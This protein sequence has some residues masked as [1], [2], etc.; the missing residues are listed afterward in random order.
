[1]NAWA[2]RHIS[3]RFGDVALSAITPADVE[4]WLAELRMKGLAAS[5][6]N[7]IL[8][9]LKS[10]FALAI[11]TCHIAH[12]RSP[13]REIRN[14]RM[15]PKQPRSLSLKEGK[16]LLDCLR[17]IHRPE[18]LI[19]QLLLLTGARK[20]EILK[21]RWEFLDCERR[22]LTVPCSKS[23]KQR[24]IYL[25]EEATRLFR[26]IK[27]RDG[28]PWILPDRNPQKPLSDVYRFWNKIRT[29]LGLRDTRIHDLRHSFASYLVMDGHT[30]Y[31]A[32]QLLG[33]SDPR[34]TMRYAHF[35]QTTL[36]AATATL[37]S[38]FRMGRHSHRDGG[39]EEIREDSINHFIYSTN[40]LE[41]KKLAATKAAEACLKGEMEAASWGKAYRKDFLDDNGLLF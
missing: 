35:A 19:I 17:S 2:G 32:Q 40:K 4:S 41:D 6:C 37:D 20:S 9:I 1:M 38:P 34:T 10:V 11:A 22:I 8:A 5:S 29:Q 27:S 30:L 15:S 14:F 39:P 33:H 24:F 36:I 31:I 13:C 7:R 21:A 26:S 12:G 23:G 3:P 25:S 16:Q 18:A 28:C